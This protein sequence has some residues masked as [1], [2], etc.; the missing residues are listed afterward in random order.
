MSS[1]ATMQQ[2]KTDATQPAQRSSQLAT[3]HQQRNSSAAQSELS[4]LR[5]QATAQRQLQDTANNSPQ[6]HQLNTFQQMAQNSARSTQ[7]KAMSAMMNA[8]AVQRVEEEEP[9]QAKS[10]T[11]TAQRDV[12]DAAEAPKPNNTGL[13][14]NLKSGVESLSGMSMDHVKVHYNSSQPAQLNA[15]AYAQGSKIHVAPGQERHL[16]HEAWHVVQQA[17]GRV[18]PTMQMKAGVPVNDDA[19]LEAEADLM[20]AKALGLGAV[21]MR[22]EGD[23]GML[24]LNPSPSQPIQQKEPKNSSSIDVN[25]QNKALNL[26]KGESNVLIQKYSYDPNPAEITV[27]LPKSTEK[28][29]ESISSKVTWKKGEIM[30]PKSIGSHTVHN[31]GW[32]GLLKNQSNG[33]NATGLHVVNANWGG[34]ANALDGNLVPGTPR[35]N[36][37]H[38]T[39]ENEVHNQFKNNGGKAPENMSYEAD[40]ITPYDQTI[41][42]TKN[43][44]G[45]EICYEDPSI[46]CT[47]IVG[48]E[49]LVDNEQVELGGGTKIVVP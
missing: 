41:D 2:A 26:A 30:D 9:L 5:P 23:V 17:Q 6:S 21:Q 12:A 43:K 14:D 36:G 27:N 13:P 48:S 35:L 29:T 24:E 37:R 34:S 38:K 47:V 25:A 18:Q 15:H 20:G 19:G 31:H 46:K 7:L 33:N 1:S 4:D 32:K 8:P 3:Q 49:T 45:D 28:W 39:I 11:E 16:P 44:S 22:K 42:L 40:V 10:A